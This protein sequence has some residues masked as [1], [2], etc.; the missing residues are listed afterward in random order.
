[1]TGRLSSAGAGGMDCSSAS[2]SASSY[3]CSG[4]AAATGFSLEVIF[5]LPIIF[6][7]ESVTGFLSSVLPEDRAEE[8]RPGT[9][10]AG[11]FVCTSLLG[12]AGACALAAVAGAGR[13]V[14]AAADRAVM[15]GAA[16][17]LL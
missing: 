8:E 7:T 10:A 11:N 1:M 15:P 2:S 3:C 6:G 4:S 17:Y 13:A 5:L 16:G 14:E 9:G 12:V